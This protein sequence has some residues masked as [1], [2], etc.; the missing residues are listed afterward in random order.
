M[1]CVIARL[2]PRFLPGVKILFLKKIFYQKDASRI[3]EE[4]KRKG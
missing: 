3:K 1:K 4:G 2:G